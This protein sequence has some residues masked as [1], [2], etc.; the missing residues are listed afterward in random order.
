MVWMSIQLFVVL[1]IFSSEKPARSYCQDLIK[2]L[3]ASSPDGLCVSPMIAPMVAVALHPIN[4]RDKRHAS[5][6]EC[7][8][9]E[10]SIGQEEI[11]K[12]RTPDCARNQGDKD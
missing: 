9:F 8:G 4:D 1:S 7:Q 6:G 10:Q 5:Y 11:D 2:D 12:R 3:K